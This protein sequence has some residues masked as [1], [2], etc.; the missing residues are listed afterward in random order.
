MEMFHVTREGMQIDYNVPIEASDGL[1]LRANI[2]RPLKNGQYPVVLAYGVYAKDLH[3]KDLYPTQYEKLKKYCPESFVG[4]TGIHM[5][6]EVVDPELWCPDG[7][8]CIRVDSRGA[9]CS[10]GHM[11]TLS[12]REAQDIYDCIEW[13]AQ[14][15][16]CNGKVGML[17]ISYYGC[18]AWQAAALNPPHLAA[19]IAW[20]G[21]S[22]YYR[23]MS[24][25]GGILCTMEDMWYYKQVLPTQ[26]GFGKYGYYSRVHGK[27]VS[28]DETLSDAERMANRDD[29]GK[30]MYDHAL[31]DEFSASRIPDLSAIK[32][33]ILSAGNWGGQ[34]LHLRG[35]IE[36][37]MRC[38]SEE[39]FLEVHG[40]EH[41]T[42]FY[43]EY[44]MKL[45]KQFFGYYLKGENTG[46]KD[47]PGRVQLQIRYPGE[48]FVERWENEFP[49][50]RTKYTKL[51][52]DPDHMELTEEPYQ[53]SNTVSYRGMSSEGLSFLTKPLE[54]EVEL[55]GHAMAK[56]LISSSTTDADLF[57]VLRVFKP[58]MTE[59]TFRGANDPH[60]PVAQG[61]LRASHRKLDPKM[62]THYR[63]YHTHDELWKLTPGEVA[64][65]DVEFYPVCIV[66]PKGY[67]IGLTI[68]GKDY[69]YQGTP[70]NAWKPVYGVDPQTGCGS[71][72]HNDPF[73]RPEEIFDGEVTLH[74]TPEQP[75]YLQ[76]PVIPE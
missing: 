56:L 47:R 50:A 4:T 20:E 54:H 35:N 19:V 45:Q 68:R 53:R 22:D 17:G 5:S 70:R 59:V 31:I 64:D 18:N 72:L 16:W 66:V 13:A 75:L 3:V 39:K 48:K 40:L 2:Y 60:A 49:L 52:L 34:G 32:A 15:P 23:D 38:G 37:F 65:C 57:L 69:E 41:F 36:G 43:T 6:W 24:H 67:R 55:T 25:H 10:P 62:S 21:Y 26:Y 8:V 74:F 7:Y 9:G 61:W 33:P 1:I 12:A 27:P 58:D 42:H 71:L 28:G 73:D 76:V 29:C 51:Y 30:E 46:W 14:Q 63:P 44:G 11:S